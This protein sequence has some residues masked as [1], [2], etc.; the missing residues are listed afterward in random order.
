MLI[1]KD[2]QKIY[3]KTVTTPLIKKKKKIYIQFVTL[4]TYL[5]MDKEYFTMHIYNAK[6]IISNLK[7]KCQ[8]HMLIVTLIFV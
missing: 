4:Q 1:L 8:N 2:N 7:S 6:V 5:M 3:A